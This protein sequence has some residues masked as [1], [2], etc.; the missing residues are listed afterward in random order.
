M[1]ETTTTLEFDPR[2]KRGELEELAIKNGLVSAKTYSNK[3][4]VIEALEKVQAGGDA[5]EIDAE[6]KQEVDDNDDASQ[7]D[8]STTPPDVSV[9]E[10]DDEPT[11]PETTPETAPNEPTKPKGTFKNRNQGHPTAFDATGRPLVR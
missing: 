1:S 5:S 3:P 8:P 10:N 9:T 11:P 2:A 6:Y 7:D 4:A